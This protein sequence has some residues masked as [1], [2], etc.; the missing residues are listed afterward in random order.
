MHEFGIARTILE[1]VLKKAEGHG[2]KKISRIALKVGQ[3]KMVTPSSLQNA[4]DLVSSGT[5]AEG[6]KLKVEEVAG[7]ELSVQSIEVDTGGLK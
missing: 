7:D 1:S 2:A 6:A 3:L 5:A 4:F